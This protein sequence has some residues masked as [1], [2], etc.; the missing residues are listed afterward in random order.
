MRVPEVLHNFI[1][2]SYNA[3][4]LAAMLGDRWG[5]PGKANSEV[6]VDDFLRRPALWL[7][8]SG[9]YGQPDMSSFT[10]QVRRG[11][12]DWVAEVAPHGIDAYRGGL[13]TLTGDQ[14]VDAENQRV[15]LM[16]QTYFSEAYAVLFPE[17]GRE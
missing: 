10:P 13:E 8:L 17:E 11:L 5:F 4:E 14:H 2:N 3:C 7:A 1:A 12:A 6:F 16:I 15:K 9:E